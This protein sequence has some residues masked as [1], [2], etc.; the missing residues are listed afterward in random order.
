MITNENDFIGV[1][2]KCKNEQDICDVMKIIELSGMSDMQCLTFIQSLSSKGIIR[3]VDTQ[4]IQIN[5]IAYSVYESP[6]KKAGKSFLKLSVSLLKFV[7][8][9]ILGIISGLIIA[10]FTHKFGWQ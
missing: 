5:P 3:S 10:Y 7:V 9:Y 1:M 2:M 4:Y 8:T 6:K